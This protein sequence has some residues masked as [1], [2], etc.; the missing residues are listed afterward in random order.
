MSVLVILRDKLTSLPSSN[1]IVEI[2]IRT[3]N[4]IDRT[5]GGG[6]CS[7]VSMSD[8]MQKPATCRLIR[9]FVATLGVGYLGFYV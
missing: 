6:K 8:P 1:V 5:R 2:D 3:H 7:G 4:G 9:A